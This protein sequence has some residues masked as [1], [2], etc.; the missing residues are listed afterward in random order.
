VS[1]LVT[2]GMPVHNGERYMAGA[3][4]SAL[5]QT[6]GDFELVISDN[7][8]SDQTES[9]CRAFAQRDSR[10]RYQR[11]DTN[12]GAARNHNLCVERSRG[13]YFMWLAYD[14]LL[15]KTQLERCVDALERDSSA[16]MSF[17]RL[18]YMDDAGAALGAQTELD[19]SLLADD[20]GERAWQLVRRQLSTDDVYSAIYSLMRRTAL[21]RTRLHGS[22]LAADQVLLFELVLAGKLVQVDGAE[23]IRRVHAASSMQRHRSPAERAVW[24]DSSSR[25]SVHLAHWTLFVQHY[26]AIRRAELPWRSKARAALAVSYRMA[27]EWRNLGGDVK[28]A[29][30]TAWAR[31]R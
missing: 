4:E 29:V 8:S 9:I 18:A 23:F 28:D 10:V 16:S 21:E 19:L 15:G 26:R 12:V 17:P 6:F 7:A 25:R 5:A 3:I 20:A 27:N 2:I 1:V 14:D 22:Y 30:R 13:T 31:R 11:V 24:F